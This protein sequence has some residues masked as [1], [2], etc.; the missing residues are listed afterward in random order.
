MKSNSIDSP[1]IILTR[2]TGSGGALSLKSF[3]PKVE[4]FYVDY[5]WTNTLTL[6]YIPVLG[7][8]K[9]VLNGHILSPG[10]NLA[11]GEDYAITEKVI[12]FIRT[13]FLET[14]K[15]VVFY[16]YNIKEQI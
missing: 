3:T 14:D 12:T 13:D 11:S 5:L 2:G 6:A 4:I 15:L 9:I 10:I 8:E 7:T 1:K 16:N